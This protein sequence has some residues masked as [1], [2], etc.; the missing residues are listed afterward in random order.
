MVLQ[1]AV[2][3]IGHRRIRN[4][5]MFRS[6]M[7]RHGI[8]K[9]LHPLFVRGRDE[10]LIIFQRSEMGIDGIKVHGAV[11]VIVLRGPVFHDGRKQQRG[12]AEILQIGQVVLYPAQVAAVVGAGFRTVVRTRRFCWLIIRRIAVREAVRHDEVHHVVLR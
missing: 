8:K 4:P 10:F 11:P 12:H 6:N 1:R 5:G 7:I 9:N 2:K 3:P